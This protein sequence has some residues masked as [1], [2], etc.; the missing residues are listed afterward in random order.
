MV[1]KDSSHSTYHGDSREPVCAGWTEMTQIS[2]L[3]HNLKT[4]VSP[5][6]T[7]QFVAPSPWHLNMLGMYT[8]RQLSSH[9]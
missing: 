7:Y 2:A 1:P 8:Y 4:H 6:R 5:H 3:E 9:S